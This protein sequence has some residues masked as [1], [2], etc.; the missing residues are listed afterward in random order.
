MEANLSLNLYY[1]K[2]NGSALLLQD[3]LFNLATA[4]R[5]R[6]FFDIQITPAVGFAGFYAESAVFSE[7]PTGMQHLFD[8]Y[9]V[10]A[11]SV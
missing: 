1:H 3:K 7:N 2:K 6:L 8:L 4:M 9:H 11:P 10:D 5:I